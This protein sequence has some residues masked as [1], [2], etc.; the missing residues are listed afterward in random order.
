MGDIFAKINEAAKVMG[1]ELSGAR[2]TEAKRI[3]VIGVEEGY[4][5]DVIMELVR[6]VLSGVPSGASAA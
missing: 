4:A 2:V 6:P 1:L 5:D 3:A